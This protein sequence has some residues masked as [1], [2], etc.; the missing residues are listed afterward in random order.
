ME[1]TEQ[2]FLWIDETPTEEE[3]D[4]IVSADYGLQNHIKLI[5]TAYELLPVIIR[6]AKYE[7]EFELAF[8]RLAIRLFNS[9]ASALKLARSGYYQPALS[10]VRDIV[11]I[12]FLMDL[13][14]REPQEL[15]YWVDL[16]PKDREKRF[17]PFKVREKLDKADG[18]K[19]ER[20]A[21]AYKRFV[22]TPRIQPQRASV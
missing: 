3:N 20:R 4:R 14:R 8:L 12:Q 9:A 5:H 6:H 19:E 17:K 7:N 2:H 18:F 15:S 10:M 13:F 1:P 11:E 21:E 16:S 22:S